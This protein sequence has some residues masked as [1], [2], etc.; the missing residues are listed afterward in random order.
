MQVR[1]TP[2]VNPGYDM[3]TYIFKVTVF[4]NQAKYGVR[5]RGLTLTP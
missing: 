4:I 3:D 2:V 5:V 1:A